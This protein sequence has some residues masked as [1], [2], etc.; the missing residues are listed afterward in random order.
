MGFIFTEEEMK[1]MK[2]RLEDNHELLE[3]I[4]NIESG[5]YYQTYEGSVKDDVLHILDEEGYVGTSEEDV[6]TITN[7]VMSKHDDSDYNELISS[8][9]ESVLIYS[10]IN[11]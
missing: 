2:E 4:S 11:G 6:Q 3:K 9:I 8:I 1:V 10:R 7:Q 5:K